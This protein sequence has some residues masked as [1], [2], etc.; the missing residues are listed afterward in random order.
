MTWSLP[1]PDRWGVDAIRPLREHVDSQVQ[2]LI[3]AIAGSAASARQ[4]PK[5]VHHGGAEVWGGFTV[6]L[7]R[8]TGLRH[9]GD[10]CHPHSGC[11]VR[12]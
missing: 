2:D 4:V 3:A 1:N 10:S 11:L 5:C 7:P 9:E 6:V 12:T 8:R